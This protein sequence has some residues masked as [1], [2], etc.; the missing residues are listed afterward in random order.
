MKKYKHAYIVGRMCP[1]HLGHRRLIRS[2]IDEFGY[3]NSLLLI[4]SCNE[5]QSYRN[6]FDYI[7]RRSFV[8]KF[9]QNYAYRVCRILSRAT[10][11]GNSRPLT[12]WLTAALIQRKPSY[13]PDQ[14]KTVKSL[15][16]MAGKCFLLIGTVK[17]F[18]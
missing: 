1:M 14:W 11:S 16:N 6:I 2:M 4:G 8:K 5:P 10:I 15:L 9:S 18:L 3:R 7:Q 12:C 17:S 13:I